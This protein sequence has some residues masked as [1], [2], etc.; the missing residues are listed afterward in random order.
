MQ[1][2][3]DLPDPISIV[4]PTFNEG[5]NIPTLLNYLSQK[6]T[7]ADEIIIADGGSEDETISFAKKFR[8]TTCQSA[9]GRARQMNEGARLAKTNILY[10]LHADT[11]PPAGFRSQIIRAIND[12]Y[13]LGRFRTQF[14]SSSPLLKVNAFLTRFDWPI[15]SGGDQSLFITRKAFDAVDGFNEKL[16]LMEDYDIVNRARA[17]FKYKIIP[18]DM[19][20]S[21]R[22]YEKNGWLKVQLA[23]YKIVRMYRA[24]VSQDEL[25]KKYRQLLNY[26]Y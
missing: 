25:M 3:D 2:H 5:A 13:H 16:Q 23:H 6:I 17:N 11:V 22:K 14:K 15:C 9:M 7:A 10:F 21:A 24:G 19:L 18:A 20:I 8:V 4:I 12:G 1:G 26:R